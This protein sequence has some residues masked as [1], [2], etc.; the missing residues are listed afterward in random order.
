[1][2]EGRA[3]LPSELPRLDGNADPAVV[4]KGLQRTGLTVATVREFSD[5]GLDFVEP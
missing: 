3:H 5:L 1:M 4:M 2:T